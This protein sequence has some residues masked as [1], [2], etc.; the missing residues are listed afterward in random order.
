MGGDIDLFL[1]APPFTVI[2]KVIANCIRS[3]LPDI[4]HEAQ[5]SFITGRNFVE[6]VALAHDLC[7]NMPYNMFIVKFDL[8]KAF[9]SIN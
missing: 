5:S 9:D 1:F 7:Y 2:A 8:L 3:I 6:N 4:I